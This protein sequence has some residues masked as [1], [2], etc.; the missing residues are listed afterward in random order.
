M[1]LHTF[2]NNDEFVKQSTNFIAEIC[3]NPANIAL[4]GGSTPK[5][6]YENL[7]SQSLPFDKL[8]FYQVDERY[9]PLDHQ[10]SNCRMIFDSL[11][12]KTNT[13]FHYFDTNLPIEESLEKYE[14]ELPQD[15]FDLAILGIGS[16][17]HTAS[18]F[19]NTEALDESK[20]VAHTKT[21]EFTIN[22]RL[23]L[24]FPKILESKKLLVLL[25]GPS[26]QKIVEELQS[27][28]LSYKNFPA[29]KLTE[30]PDLT[31]H[32]SRG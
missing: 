21:Q 11:V 6:I 18:L 14:K 32:F 28:T 15:P 2:Q 26:K 5:T 19:P 16:D 23:T 7:A 27:H 9:I 24:T 22:D 17:G 13:N 3:K 25:S 8:N 10:D 30:H 20:P 1:Q 29:K 4:S 31:I 12:N